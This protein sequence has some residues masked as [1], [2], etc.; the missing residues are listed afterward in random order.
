MTGPTADAAAPSPVME[1]PSLGELLNQ[2]ALATALVAVVVALVRFGVTP[3][4]LVMACFLGALGALAV[5]DL[6]RHLLPNAIIYPAAALVLGLQLVLF[7][8]Q[9]LEWVVASVGC[10]AVMLILSLIKP[11]GLGMGDV[12]L[13]LL[14]GAGL[15][16]DVVLAVFLG[17]LLLWPVAL[18]ILVSGGLEA[19]KRALPLG[20]ALAL[21]AAVVALA[22]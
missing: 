13:G 7:P 10:F 19:R 4:G 12:K 15:G 18:W 3:R 20:P 21:G 11:G 17:F 14:L 6:Q 8:D 5:I 1:R 2:P 16:E 9:A 22:G